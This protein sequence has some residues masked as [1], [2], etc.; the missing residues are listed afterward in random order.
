M[1]KKEYLDKIIVWEFK[2]TWEQEVNIDLIKEKWS[3]LWY[4]SFTHFW[5]NPH[6]T[7]VKLLRNDSE[8]TDI[9]LTISKEQ[10]MKIAKEL[11]LIYQKSSM[12]R[13]AWT[14]VK[15]N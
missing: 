12:F 15:N 8:I 5:E 1:W 11:D 3:H 13:N 4:I 2:H 9:K 7:L 10:A 6:Y 14:Y